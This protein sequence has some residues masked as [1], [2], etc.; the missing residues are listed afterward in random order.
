MLEFQQTVRHTYTAGR[1]QRINPQEGGLETEVHSGQQAKAQRAPQPHQR[2]VVALGGVDAPLEFALPLRHRPR[3]FGI[4]RA[5]SPGES[6]KEHYH[7][8]P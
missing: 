4:E 8:Y 2:A 1:V 5:G 7:A 3:I 6:R